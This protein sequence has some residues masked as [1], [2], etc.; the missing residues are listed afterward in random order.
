MS[1]ATFPPSRWLFYGALRTYGVFQNADAQY[2]REWF[3]HQRSAVNAVHFH[4][5]RPHYTN[6]SL[7]V[8]VRGAIS[9]ARFATSLRD[10]GLPLLRTC[11]NFLPHERSR[12]LD[13]G[14]RL[15][16]ARWA[17]VVLALSEEARRL[18]RRYFG[19]RGPVIVA[20]H[21]YYIGV[22]PRRADRQTGRHALGIPPRAF[23]YLF[24]GQ[25]RPYKGVDD[26]ITSFA[27]LPDPDARL[28]IAG[29]RY[30]RN[31]EPTC[32]K[33]RW[34]TRGSIQS[35]S[36]FR[37]SRSRRSSRRPAW[38]RCRS[39]ASSAP[40]R[41]C[42]R[43]PGGRPVIIPREPSL[44][45]YVNDRTAYAF[46]RRETL[47]DALARVRALPLAHGAETIWAAQFDWEQSVE[48][49]AR[50]L[51]DRSWTRRSHAVDERCPSASRSQ[52]DRR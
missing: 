29:V 7:E 37:T 18:V 42:S 30:P 48:P 27:S 12:V 19:R 41:S 15:L 9:L 8:S 26:L 52:T 44:L 33:V 13:Y 14:V 23:V 6:P 39:A 31:T 35:S 11:H 46:A 50:V 38:R 4:R 16:F 51:L 40:A 49:L 28:V 43:S 3:R 20:R 32:D 36:R 2:S 45:E 17:D 24:F 1:M 25:V 34:A 10:E 21:G 47:T 22:N 5:L